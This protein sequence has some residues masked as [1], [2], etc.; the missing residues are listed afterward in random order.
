MLCFA[1]SQCNGQTHAKQPGKGRELF[2]IIWLYLIHLGI[3]YQ[4]VV[5]K[6]GNVFLVPCNQTAVAP[7]E[8]QNNNEDSTAVTSQ[9]GQNNNEDSTGKGRTT[10]MR[11]QIKSSRGIQP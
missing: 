4:Y 11:I 5:K 9:E 6:T 3:S 7:Q 8:G 2:T 1:A 10:L